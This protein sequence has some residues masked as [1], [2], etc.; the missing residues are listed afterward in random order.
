MT[1]WGAGALA[2]V[3]GV[4]LAAGIGCETSRQTSDGRPMPP[5]PRDAPATPTAAPINAMAIVLGPKP[6]DTNGNLRPD[7]IQIEAYLFAR[8]HPTPVWRAGTFEFAI[9][10]PGAAGTPE[11][12]NPDPIRTWTLGPDRLLE[13]RSRTLIGESYSIG[14]SLLENA[15]SDDLGMTSVDLLAVWRPVDGG[16]PVFIQGVRT[17]S[18]ATPMSGGRGGA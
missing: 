13:L 9:Y 2:I 11:R 8:P 1:R 14:L 3:C 17:V 7:L 5:R 6:V 16:A 15:A 12:P 18:L 10:P 4:A